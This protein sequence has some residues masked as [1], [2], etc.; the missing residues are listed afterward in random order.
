MD[1]QTVE[2]LSESAVAI[3]GLLTVLLMTG[4]R[5]LHSTVNALPGWKKMM[6]MWGI[7]F[8]LS[9][10]G[11][12]TGSELSSLSDL[13]VQVNAE[14]VAGGLLSMGFWHGGKEFLRF[15]HRYN[16]SLENRMRFTKGPA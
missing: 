6:L 12:L 5:M 14:A 8:A 11:K 1:A 13:L 4:A 15:S 16:R 2:V 9:W 7:S 10:L 3:K